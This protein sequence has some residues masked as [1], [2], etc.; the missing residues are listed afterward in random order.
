MKKLKLPDTDRLLGLS[1]IL[2]SL[3]TLIVFFY[4]TSLIRK[5]Q[6]MSVYPYLEI[7]HTGVHTKEYSFTVE[8]KGVGPAIIEDFFVGKKGKL[9]QQ[10]FADFFLK[11]VKSNEN[12]RISYAN[13]YSGKLISENEIVEIFKSNDTTDYSSEKLYS[14]LQYENM[15]FELIYSSVY[16]EKWKITH[17]SAKPIK[18]SE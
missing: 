9:I 18:L 12:L 16:G 4:Q 8:N 2:L 7:G 13:L 11:E 5:Q 15:E 1:A 14:I 6:Y 10:D 3:C 17:K